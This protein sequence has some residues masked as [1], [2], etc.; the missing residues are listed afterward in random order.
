MNNGRD[1]AGNGV[2]NLAVTRKYI[3]ENPAAGVKHFNELRDRPDRRML[4]VEEELLILK[5]APPYPRFDEQA[6]C[7]SRF[8]LCG[9]F[10][11]LDS[12]SSFRA[13]VCGATRHSSPETTRRYQLGMAEELRQAGEKS[14]R[15]TYGGMRVRFYDVRPVAKEKGATAIRN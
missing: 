9:T 4:T 14:N 6:P 15:K 13:R 5:A 1:P 12:A 2:L 11:A 7:I 8:T 10:S 3:P